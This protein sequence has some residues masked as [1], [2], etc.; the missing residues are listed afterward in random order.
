MH[1]RMYRKTAKF[2][3][4][5]RHFPIE[6]W[7]IEFC[8][9]ICIRPA[10]LPHSW[11]SPIETKFVFIY[12]YF[13]LLV[14]FLDPVQLLS[15]ATVTWHRA[16]SPVTNLTL[17]P[18]PSACATRRTHKSDLNIHKTT[19]NGHFYRNNCIFS[20]F[21]QRKFWLRFILESTVP[22]LV[23]SGL[24]WAGVSCDTHTHMQDFITRR[25]LC[26]RPLNQT[27]VLTIAQAHNA[28]DRAGVDSAAS[29]DCAYARNQ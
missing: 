8:I 20:P 29:A 23:W 17:T 3:K 6:R 2:D 9:I 5:Y 22:G 28:R 13:N 10:P 4:L 14:P 12:E 21:C 7:S 25:R 16:D 18:A 15:F 19:V 1:I 11:Y 27:S 24:V 26:P